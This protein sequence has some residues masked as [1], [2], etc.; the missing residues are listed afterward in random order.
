MFGHMTKHRYLRSK[1][2]SNLERFGMKNLLLWVSAVTALLAVSG[3]AAAQNSD[4]PSRVARIAF[5]TGPVSFEPAS[6]DQWADASVNYPMTTGDN[7]YTDNGARAVLRIGQNS[8]R[9][10]SGTNFQ[11]VNLS[12]NVVQT[13]INSGSLSLRVRHLVDGESWEVDTPNGAITFLRPGEYRVDC[14]TSRNATMVTVRSGDIDVTANN[15]SFAVH[16]GQTAY[17]DTTG[18]P[19]DVQDANQPDD[20]DS[21]VSSRDRQEDAPPPQYV[22]PD[23]VGYEDLNANGDWRNTS[24]NGPVWTPHVAAGW[25][26]YHDGRW[27]WV[28]PWGWTWIDDAPWG[29]APFHYGRWAYADNS[30]GWYPGAIAPRP[31]YAP[32]LVAF[33]GGGGFSVGVSVGGGGGLVGWF[34]LGPREV[35]YPSYHVSEGYTRQVNVTN[36]RIT[37]INV[38]NINVTNINYVNRNAIV[39]VPQ[40]SFAS[41]QSVQRAAVRVDANQMRQAQVIGAAPRV[42]PVQASVLGNSSGRKAAAPPA[43]I[44]NRAVVAKLAPPPRAVP[45]AAKQQMLQQHP[46]TPVAPAQLQTLRTQ[47]SQNPA[48]ARMQVQSIDT[49]QVRPVT[50]TVRPGPAPTFVQRQAQPNAPRQAPAERQQNQAV[51]AARPQNL[52]PAREQ[53]QPPASQAP[54]V[55]EQVQPPQRQVS[56]PVQEQ[57]AQPP[58]RQQPPPPRQ[59]PPAREQVQ[60]PQRQVSP[61]VQEQRAQPPVRQQASP[62]TQTPPAREQAQPPARQ[63]PAPAREQRAEPPVRQQPPPPRPAPPAREQVQPPARQA[64]APAKEQRAE[65]PV[66]QQAPPPRQAPPPKKEEKKADKKPEDKKQ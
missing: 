34:P 20:F 30:W 16:S 9:L 29:F 45:F 13:S 28:E 66:R 38:T 23:M 50:P 62:P 64:P 55:R 21:F 10:N 40:N 35:Y 14:D 1:R 5:I 60:P 24:D 51:P 48:P 65:P 19:P 8:I 2:V 53:A 59:A 54:P 18:N 31:Y 22:S 12:D 44:T 43:A 63:A 32:A 33:V 4:P 52:P 41:A 17:F 11:F 37:N 27:A 49:K 15:Q 47:A 61:P 36:T 6:V 56:P 46:G 3:I 26:P 58:V 39:A 57:R 25:T 7:L 42:A